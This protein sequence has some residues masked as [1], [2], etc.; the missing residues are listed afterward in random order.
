[1]LPPLCAP[2]PPSA[3]ARPRRDTSVLATGCPRRLPLQRRFPP[4]TPAAP[5]SEG[6]STARPS[7][8]ATLEAGPLPGPRGRLACGPRG[9][10]DRGPSLTVYFLSGRDR[11]GGRQTASPLDDS[12]LAWWDECIKAQLNSMSSYPA[13]RPILLT[14]PHESYPSLFHPTHLDSSSVRTHGGQEEDPMTPCSQPRPG[15]SCN[16]HSRVASQGSAKPRSWVQIPSSPLGNTRQR[17]AMTRPLLA[18][19]GITAAIG[20]LQA[21]RLSR[22][23]DQRPASALSFIPVSCLR[24]FRK[25]PISKNGHHRMGTEASGAAKRTRTTNLVWRASRRRSR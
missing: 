25:S 3:S 8:P 13:L 23:A 12:G 14:S 6:V 9:L 11:K 24:A 4:R 21:F 16:R 7:R 18:I 19:R 22:T 1:M 10:H 2:C 5:A 17:P 15:R 20:L